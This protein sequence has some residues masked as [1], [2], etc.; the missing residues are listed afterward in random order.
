MNN[1]HDI[2]VLLK[3]HSGI[4]HKSSMFFK[5]GPGEYAE[6]DHFLGVAVPTLRKIAQQFAH[7]SLE[8]IQCL[9]T[10][11]N[12][13]ERLLALFI[14]ILQYR[15]A[16]DV[17]KYDIYC[18]Y[19]RNLKHIN[20]W[21]LVDASA[22]EIV[23][24]YL[25]HFVSSKNI[26]ITLAQSD[27]VWE[28]RVAIIATRYFIGKLD[29]S[30]TFTIAEILL[31]DKHDLIH[32]AVGWMLRE[33]GKKDQALLRAFL[34]KHASKMPRT[35]LRYAIEKFSQHERALFIPLSNSKHQTSIQ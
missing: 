14:L 6:H 33:V 25:F 4:S 29:F 20:N 10:S 27:N 11:K 1:M 5:T 23:G 31:S 2:Q 7:I 13:E 3:K 22:R 19:M 17:V 15:K 34:D 21:N 9:L 30:L 8:E 28:R 24:S 18:F 26:L 35:M 16:N 32:K 12:N